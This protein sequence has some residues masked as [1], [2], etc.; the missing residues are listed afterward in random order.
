M[1]DPNSPPPLFRRAVSSLASVA[2]R[3]ELV[4]RA[5][6][7]PPRLAPYSWATSVEADIGHRGDGTDDLDEPDTSGRLILLHDPDGQDRWQG[8]FRLVCFVQARLEPGQLGDDML[9]RIG[10]S[11]LTDALGHAGAAFTALGGTVTQTA[12][13]RFGGLGEASLTA[14]DDP[15]REDDVELRAS[16]TPTESD[17]DLTRHAVAFGS[18]VATAAGLPPAGAVPLSRS[19]G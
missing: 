14:D 3:P 10:W 19:P 8:T 18:L 15:P 17:A 1:P 13:V 9:P 4:V 7:A 11:W 2:P 6:E 5:L 12:S 16:W